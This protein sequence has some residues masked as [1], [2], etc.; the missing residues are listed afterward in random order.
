MV[1]WMYQLNG[2]EC[3]QLRHCMSV[4]TDRSFAKQSTI[5]YTLWYTISSLDLHDN[6]DLLF[7][8]FLFF[9]FLF[10]FVCLFVF[11]FRTRML[12][13]RYLKTRESQHFQ[14]WDASKGP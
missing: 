14:T 9:L 6:A 12:W 8:L 3:M 4:N 7:L 1:E 5:F 10:F 11:L 13:T 2:V